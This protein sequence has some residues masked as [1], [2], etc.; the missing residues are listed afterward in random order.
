LTT[1]ARTTLNV[2]ADTKTRLKWKQ[3]LK[4][5]FSWCN[6]GAEKNNY[7]ILYTNCTFCCS[8]LY[9]MT[10]FQTY[11]QFH[12]IFDRADNWFREIC[13]ICERNLPYRFCFLPRIINSGEYTLCT[14][15]RS[16]VFSCFISCL[17]FKDYC[18][19]IFLLKLYNLQKHENTKTLN[20]GQKVHSV[21]SPFKSSSG[22]DFSWF[23]KLLDLILSQL[24]LT[25]IKGRAIFAWK[26]SSKI[27]RKKD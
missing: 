16:F 21:Y 8:T 25:W 26:F 11:R 15:G 3:A 1:S 17:L 12:Q 4:V 2:G 9:C 7:A 22:N 20:Y 19:L 10:Q 23:S 5:V 18:F 13:H 14:F 24:L 27:L 6:F